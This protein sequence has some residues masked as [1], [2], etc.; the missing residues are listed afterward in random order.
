MSRREARR[1]HRARIRR[2]MDEFIP[3]PR[4]PY[5]D[6][7]IF[8]AVLS[9]CLVVIA[10]VTGAGLVRGVIVGAV[11]FVIATGFSWWRFREKLRQREAE[12]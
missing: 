1:A 11:F 9:A 10:T 5:R 4:H 3:L 7:A 6:S 8:Y 12:Q 2:N